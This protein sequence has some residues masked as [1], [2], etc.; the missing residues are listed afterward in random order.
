VLKEFWTLFCAA[1]SYTFND[2]LEKEMRDNRGTV[3]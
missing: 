2:E 3:H 1:G